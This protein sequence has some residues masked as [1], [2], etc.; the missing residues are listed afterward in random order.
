[1]QVSLWGYLGP[2]TLTAPLSTTPTSLKTLQKSLETIVLWWVGIR[3]NNTKI[4]MPDHFWFIQITILT[5][6]ANPLTYT[7]GVKRGLQSN[8]FLPHSLSAI[9]SMNL[10]LCYAEFIIWNDSSSSESLEVCDKCRYLGPTREIWVKEG[11][12][13]VPQVVLVHSPGWACWHSAPFAT[14]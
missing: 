10:S 13:K 2:W 3:L 4:T 14:Y 1:M 12:S 5:F 9:Y 7:Q 6:N 11:H 8:L